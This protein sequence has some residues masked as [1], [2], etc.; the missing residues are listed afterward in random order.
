MTPVDQEL[1]KFA[2]QVSDV[3]GDPGGIRLVDAHPIS[4]PDWPWVV[5]V[6]HLHANVSTLSDQITV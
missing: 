6:P 4:G 3:S 2:P 5:R 1:V